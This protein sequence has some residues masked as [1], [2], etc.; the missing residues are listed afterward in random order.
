MVALV[1]SRL[2]ITICDEFKIKPSSLTLWSNSKSVLHWLHSVSTLLKAFVRVS[3]TEIQSTWDPSLRWF[4]PTDQTPAD[5]LS[6]GISV[7]EING[8]WKTGPEFLKK[9]SKES[10]PNEN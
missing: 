5:D 7:E 10:P 8:H 1:A 4:V 6:R 3:V 9:P 2:E